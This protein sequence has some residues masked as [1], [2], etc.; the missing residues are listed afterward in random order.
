MF[1]RCACQL[2]DYKV[3]DMIRTPATRP[4]FAVRASALDQ[5]GALLIRK[6]YDIFGVCPG[7][8]SHTHK[9]VTLHVDAPAWPS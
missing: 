5:P 8:S 2:T 3:V 7:H 9:Y 6:L 4:V 1:L